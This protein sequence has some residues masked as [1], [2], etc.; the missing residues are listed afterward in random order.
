MASQNTCSYLSPCFQHASD[1]GW[2]L[3]L[4]GSKV[5][6]VTPLPPSLLLLSLKQPRS[7]CYHTNDD[8]EWCHLTFFPHIHFNLTEWCHLTFFS[9]IHFNLTEWC[10]L[11]FFSHIHFNLTEWCHLT[12]FSHIHHTHSFQS[13]WMVPFD[14]LFTHSCQSHWM[15]PF[16]ILFTHS[17]Q[18]PNCVMNSLQ[19]VWRGHN[20]VMSMLSCVAHQTVITC[21]MPSATRYEGTAQ[22]LSLTKLKSLL[23]Y[24][25]SVAEKPSPL[26]EGRKP[27]CPEKPPRRWA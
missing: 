6:S 25:I 24:L 9:H 8:T 14:I 2:Y 3:A 10:H 21:N 17:C 16:D 7:G 11:T 19:H 13:H 20:H 22:L 23:F 12:F 15:V 18:S 5:E 4:L 1:T 26:Q 27:D